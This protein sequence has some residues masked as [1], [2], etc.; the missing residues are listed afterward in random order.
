MTSCGHSFNLAIVSSCAIP[1]VRNRIDIVKSL[2]IWIKSS[3]KHE[4][5]LKCV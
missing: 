5:L 4:G 3:P 1:C 2:R